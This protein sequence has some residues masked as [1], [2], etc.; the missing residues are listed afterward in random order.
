MSIIKEYP[1][2]ITYYEL[3]CFGRMK[4]S[5]ILRLAH[6]AADLN[7]NQLGIGYHALKDNG[8]GFVLQ[9]F[10]L[11]AKR[12]P[13][14]EEPI[15]IRTWPGSVGKGIF[16]RHGIMLGGSDEALMEWTSLWVLFDLNERKILRPSALPIPL[17]GLGTLGVAAEPMKVDLSSEWGEGYTKYSHTVRF[18]ETD[19]YNHM[20]N[21]FYGDMVAN[22]IYMNGTTENPFEWKNAQ[23]NYLSEIRMGDTVDIDCKRN[24][25]GYRVMGILDGK[26]VFSA[27]VT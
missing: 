22:A 26:A 7:A 19:T 17:T 14:Y 23:I 6:I 11:E 25:K 24:E 9:R 2:S 10:G 27:V 13:E 21:I 1:A 8:I 4:L 5:S 12:L 18:S 20:N 3:D 16:L 15:L